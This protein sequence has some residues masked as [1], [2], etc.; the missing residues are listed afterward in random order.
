MTARRPQSRVRT[1]R[2]AQWT[3]AGIA[4]LT[5]SVQPACRSNKQT[6]RQPPPPP[7][8][9]PVVRGADRGLEVWSWIV[10]DQRRVTGREEPPEG[11]PA[12]TPQAEVSANTPSHPTPIRVTLND[13]RKDIESLLAP[14]LDRPVPMSTES[15]SRWRA[16]GFRI[17][18]VP[19]ADLE[20]I[21]AACRIVGQVQ[22][23]WLG[24]V[25]EWT[26]AVRGPTLQERR[27]ITLDNGVTGLE[28]GRLRLL[29]RCWTIPSGD[30]P[31]GA[32]PAAHV[33]IAPRHDPTVPERD[34]MLA[35]AGVRPEAQ[36]QFLAQLATSFSVREETALVF[37]PDS[38]EAEWAATATPP[39][40]DSN[41]L[42]FG[43]NP[44]APASLGEVMFSSPATRTT[45]RSRA[46]IALVI[47]IPARF[48][49]LP[50]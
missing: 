9:S 48:D 34:R 31:D 1:P 46:I 4:A 7:I 44:V 33:E 5:L 41:S 27:V 40:A 8:A 15:V 50:R 12:E 45:P 43:P 2:W 47:H 23:Q 19:I 13:G 6:S 25:A 17:V 3:G 20:G 30:G 42:T 21:Q 35:A 11:D 26:D 29:V 24:D 22:R 49:L 32:T 36:P 18:S 10:A 28:P 38:P 37:V 39:P 14:Y 16:S